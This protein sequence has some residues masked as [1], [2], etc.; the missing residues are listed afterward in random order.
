[1]ISIDEIIF[2]FSHRLMI[3]SSIF[4]LNNQNINFLFIIFV[5]MKIYLFMFHCVNF[6]SI[7]NRNHWWISVYN[8]NEY[9]YFH[10]HCQRLVDI[11]NLFLKNEPKSDRVCLIHSSGSEVLYSCQ[12]HHFQLFDEFGVSDISSPSNKF[13]NFCHWVACASNHMMAVFL[14]FIIFLIYLIYFFKTTKEKK[15]FCFFRFFFFFLFSA[16]TSH[17]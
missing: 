8:K 2:T 7:N 12:W 1:M 15:V 10:S 9:Q 11:F 14:I 6:N 16:K 3:F 13:E 17:W 5:V 4:I